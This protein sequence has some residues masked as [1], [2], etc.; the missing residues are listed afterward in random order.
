MIAIA[1]SVSVLIDMNH[2]IQLPA[3]LSEAER[4]FQE[5]EARAGRLTSVALSFT[6]IGHLILSILVM[7]VIP[8]ILEEIFFRGLVQ[9]QFQKVMKNPHYAIFLTAFLFSLIH[10]QFYGFIPRLLLGL[11]FGYLFFWSKNIWYP[12]AAH[13]TSNLIAIVGVHFFDWKIGD[14]DGESSVSPILFFSSALISTVCIF[15]IKKH[16]AIDRHRA[17]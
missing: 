14:Y 8:G 7:G 5:S 15:Y 3:W 4:Y 16:F 17:V 13:I 11:L 6:E 1:P 10:F 12:V 9:A 2:R